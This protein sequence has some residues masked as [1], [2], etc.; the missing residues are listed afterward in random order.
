MSQRTV[1]ILVFTFLIII[2]VMMYLFFRSQQIKA[3]Q[4]M[5][6]AQIAAITGIET[7]G[8]GIGGFLD[9]LTKIFLVKGLI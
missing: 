8:S 3:K 4:Q 6:Q 9:D 2:G 1:V 5:Q 7:T